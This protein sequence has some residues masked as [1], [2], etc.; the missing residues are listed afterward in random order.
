MGVIDYP[1]GC[2]DAAWH[3]NISKAAFSAHPA[4]NV[5]TSVN[6]ELFLRKG[7]R[8]PPSAIVDLPGEPCVIMPDPCV[9]P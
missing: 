3:A 1:V 2:L 8:S 6:M 4:L 7:H 9:A 5:S